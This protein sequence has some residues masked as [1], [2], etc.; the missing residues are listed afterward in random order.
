MHSSSC[1]DDGIKSL[2]TSNYL[3]RQGMVPLSTF[4]FVIMLDFFS[5]PKAMK[6]EHTQ[7]ETS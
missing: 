5:I 4:I 7:S 1:C 2:F 3:A 6:D